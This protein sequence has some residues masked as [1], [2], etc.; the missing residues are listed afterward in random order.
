MAL[1]KE[2]H[3][4]CLMAVSPADAVSSTADT[5]RASWPTGVP[6]TPIGVSPLT[7]D[8]TPG[9]AAGPAP[10]QDR[11]WDNGLPISLEPRARPLYTSN[12]NQE[13]L[14]CRLGGDGRTEE[15]RR[16]EFGG[17]RAS[18][19]LVCVHFRWDD[20]I[21][22]IPEGIY[23]APAPRGY[24]TSAG[25]VELSHITIALE[26][27]IH[28]DH[29]M[30]TL[31]PKKEHLMSHIYDCDHEQAQEWIRNRR[32]AHSKYRYV[33]PLLD[34]CLRLLDR[35]EA[36][37]SRFYVNNVKAAAH[38]VVRVCH[39]LC[40]AIKDPVDE[41]WQPVGLRLNSRGQMYWVD[42]DVELRPVIP[43]PRSHHP[44]R[45]YE[46]SGTFD[47]LTDAFK[48]AF[49]Q[50]GDRYK[51]TNRLMP[52]NSLPHDFSQDKRPERT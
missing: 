37:G 23:N 28:A 20:Q 42:T 14:Y 50:S 1:E 3:A 34:Y 25:L 40:Q 45:G 2:F 41:I 44:Y 32:P 17:P 26:K 7:Y 39:Y 51:L 27:G 30:D 35:F 33:Q 13:V 36:N 38:P 47:P 5:Q 18:L 4:H 31:N 15:G 19:A 12:P 9:S 46:Y 8:P 24:R 11:P 6:F 43:P 29:L 52:A 22:I 10:P 49:V 16:P 21:I 48:R